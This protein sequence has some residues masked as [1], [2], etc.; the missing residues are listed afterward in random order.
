MVSILPTLVQPLL[1]LQIR[2]L[3]NGRLVVRMC[4]LWGPHKVPPS[5][6]L[7]NALPQPVHY[8]PD[9][10]LLSCYSS[11]RSPTA[12]QS[13]L[14]ITTPHHL[15]T[16]PHSTTDPHLTTQPSTHSLPGIE[17]WTTT[18][19]V[20]NKGPAETVSQSDLGGTI[21]S[22]TRARAGGLVSVA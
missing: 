22:G 5:G 9:S 17:S 10:L 11:S 18:G 15:P 4:L 1:V 21:T 20:L 8:Y 19:G 12:H 2:M 14:L 13:I 3:H 16:D 7:Q 6:I